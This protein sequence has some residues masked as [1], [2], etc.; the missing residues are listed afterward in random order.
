M[1]FLFD[2]VVKFTRPSE[3]AGVGALGYSGLDSEQE[4]LLRAGIAAHVQFS[5]GARRVPMPVLPGSTLTR[6]YFYIYVAAADVRFLGLAALLSTGDVV[7]D[8]LARRFQID[9]LY[10]NPL[11][12]KIG[13]EQLSM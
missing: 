10:P 2:R 8:D 12:L 3:D 11:G 13:A 7:T 9:Q 1:S 4:D 6:G 5:S